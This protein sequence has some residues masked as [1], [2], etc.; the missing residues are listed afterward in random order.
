M[1]CLFC[2]RDADFVKSGNSYCLSCLKELGWELLE[3]DDIRT[4]LRRE[5]HFVREGLSGGRTADR[6]L[7]ELEELDEL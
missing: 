5:L 2:G 1:R 3:G 6:I 4:K 7:F